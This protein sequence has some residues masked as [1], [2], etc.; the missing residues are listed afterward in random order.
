MRLYTLAIQPHTVSHVYLAY[1]ILQDVAN[2][3]DGTPLKRAFFGRGRCVSSALKR[4][5]PET[6]VDMLGMIKAK[7]AIR[8]QTTLV[9]STWAK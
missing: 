3:A 2:A 6:L 9:P 7:D 1:L 5:R 8:G 4:F